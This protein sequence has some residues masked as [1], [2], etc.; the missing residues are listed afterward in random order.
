MTNPKKWIWL[1]CF[2]FTSFT[3]S[4]EQWMR[5]G[6]L[7]EFELIIQKQER[8]KELKTLCVLQLKKKIVPHFCYE[9]LQYKSQKQK[10]SFLP[11]LNEKCQEFSTSLK[12]PKKIK[13]ILQN[14]HQ[15]NHFCY[16][17]LYKQKKRIEYQ[18]R[19]QNPS[20]ILRWHFT[21]EEF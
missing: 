19:D 1:S 5:A 10:N 6:D 21:D 14:S 15:L 2:V 20:Y 18:L 9:W 12:N 8:Q 4:H 7:K 16:K 3:S 17:I 11:Y 13:E